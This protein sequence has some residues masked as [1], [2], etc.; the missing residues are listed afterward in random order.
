M[1]RALLSRQHIELES[2]EE[3]AIPFFS[4]TSISCVSLGK[5]FE[6]LMCFSHHRPDDT[7]FEGGM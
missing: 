2:T 6:C 4:E 1:L 7:P 5:R 3:E